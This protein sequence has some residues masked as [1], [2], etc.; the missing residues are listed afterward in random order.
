MIRHADARK[1]DKV[2]CDILSGQM[3]GEWF[4]E[5]VRHLLLNRHFIK[6]KIRRQKLRRLMNTNNR[7]K[8]LVF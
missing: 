7:D 2:R 5:T 1:T 6:D 4:D 3:S 8:A